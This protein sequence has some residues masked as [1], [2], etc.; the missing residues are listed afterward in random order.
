MFPL[1]DTIAAIASPPGGA[2]RG[3]IRISGP[4]ALE[5]AARLFRSA[6]ECQESD[7]PSSFSR[8][9]K[10]SGV[11]CSPCDVASL[12][13]NQPR[14]TNKTSGADILVCPESAKNGRQECL[15]H[16]S[17]APMALAGSLHLPE[18]H[19]PIPCDLYL[20]GRRPACA[21]AIAAET[22]APQVRS[23]TGQPVAEIHTLGSPPLLEMILRAVCAAGARL[24]GP[25][26]FTLRAFLA[27]RIDLT[28]AEAVLGAIDAADRRALDAALCQLAGGLA[29]PLH[30]LR[31]ELLELLAHVEAGFDFVDEALPFISREE[32]DRKL[33]EATDQL[34]ALE[35]QMLARAEPGDIPRAVLVGRP[36]SG[37]S[38][39]FNAVVGSASALVSHHAGTTRDYLTADLDLD[40][41][42]CRL[43]D[44][45]GIDGE[46][47][48]ASQTA[49]P[50]DI[51]DAAQRAAESQQRLADVQVLCLDA[52]RPLDDWEREQIEAGLV[53]RQRIVVLTKCDAARRISEVPTGIATS[54]ITG[55]GIQTLQSEL[56]RRAIA[57]AGSQGDVVASTATRCRESLQ[58]A[59]QAL[60]RARA[61][62]GE[63]ELV[64][65]DVRLALEEIGK[66]VGAVYTEDLLDRIFSRFCVGK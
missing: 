39:L 57:D 8:A 45:A 21:A 34:A 5:C 32:L 35:R 59:Q 3:I 31:D 58:L 12:R 63:E 24:A 66:V 40:G 18:L 55:E 62:A 53:G 13:S 11:L 36:N 2:A 27:G 7:I 54:S 1:D 28:Q 17:A 33:T 26:E 9:P 37:K 47:P 44:T 30:R 65:V 46:P 52:T 60:Q 14:Q 4:A 61:A 50:S 48:A 25:G 22:A 19:S 56:R 20:W 43:I 29:R 6:I 15:P 38:S 23:Y 51:E 16:Y 49:G 41:V 10:G 42:K 64:A